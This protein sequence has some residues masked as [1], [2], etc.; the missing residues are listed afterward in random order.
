MATK[1]ITELQLR[2]EVTDGLSIPSDDGIQSYRVTA[3]QFKNYVAPTYFPPVL[4]K[5]TTGSGTFYLP[6]SFLCTTANATVG[7]TYTHNSVTYTVVKTVASSTVVVMSGSAAP[8]SSGTLTK[9]SGT[10]DTTI[11]F[12]V[13]RAPLQL[14]A[15]VLGGGGVGSPS[16]TTTPTLGSNGG[17]TTFGNLTAGGGVK[18]A[19][20]VGSAAGG[21]GTVGSGWDG[22]AIPGASGSK[23]VFGVVTT[24][25]IYLGGLGGG[26]SLAGGGPGGYT[27]GG[28]APTNSGAGGGGGGISSAAGGVSGGGGGAGATVKA[29]TAAAPAASYAYGVGAGGSGGTAGTSGALGG[30]GGDGLILVQAVYQ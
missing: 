22:I 3:L 13:S 10:G 27:T 1:R 18:G 2:D 11:A 5:I 23:G 16:G 6:Y 29:V 9:A 30:V 8:L 7:A 25:E 14:V 17:D 26:S 12:T 4:Q 21:T 24:S 19:Y 20:S 15:E 28:A